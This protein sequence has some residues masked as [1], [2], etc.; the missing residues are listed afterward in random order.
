MIRS[1]WRQIALCLTAVVPIGCAN[2]P[3]A[4]HYPVPLPSVEAPGCCGAITPAGS[5]LA[6]FLDG[7]DVDNLWQEHVRINWETGA[8]KAG[9]PATHGT[10]CSAFAAAAAKRLD[11]YLLRPPDHGQDF[12]ASAQER[13][14]EGPHAREDGWTPVTSAREAQRLANQGELVVLVFRNPDPHK[15]G[16][17]AVVHPYVKSDA[18]L[19]S[20]GP[21]TTQAGAHNFTL[22][23]AVFSFV[24]HP[25]AWPDEVKMF[26]HATKFQAAAE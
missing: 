14:L 16:H 26:A 24:M 20:E 12:L 8:P 11:I 15:P 22:G 6:A 2:G 19:A 17:I 18:A 23:T 4:P 3:H 7:L 5:R 10:H 25:G 1:G 13:W 21:T 9:S